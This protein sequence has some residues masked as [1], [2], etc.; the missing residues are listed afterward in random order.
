MVGQR[1]AAATAAGSAVEQLKTI[2]VLSTRIDWPGSGG[3]SLDPEALRILQ[4]RASAAVVS[5]LSRHEAIAERLPSGRVLGFFGVPVVH[6]DDPIRA[7]RAALEIR[8]TIAA[9]DEELCREARI[10]VAA[11]IGIDSGEVIVGEA[12]L[13]VGSAVAAAEALADRAAT[14]TILVGDGTARLTAASFQTDEAPSA[15]ELPGRQLL[16]MT[17][18][19]SLAQIRDRC[20][21][22]RD[23]ELEGLRQAFLVAV[24]ERLPQLVTV[25]GEA[26]IGKSR[27]AREFTASVSSEAIAL[28]G[29]CLPYGD[30]I[31]YWPLTEIVRHAD[32]AIAAGGIAQLLQDEPDASLISDRLARGIGMGQKQTTA[33]ETAW[34]ARRFFQVLAHRR[35]LVLLFEDL[36]WAE[37]GLLD[38]IEHVAD[39]AVD[40]PILLLCLARPQLLDDRASWG[41]G[42]RNAITL[43]LDSLSGAESDALLAGLSGQSGLTAQTRARVKAV[44]EG[45]PLFLEQSAAMFA[46]SGPADDLAVPP[47]IQALLVAR[48]ERLGPGER[49]VIECASIAGRDFWHGSVARAPPDGGSRACSE[50]PIDTRAKGAD[51]T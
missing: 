15:G 35:P 33:E 51:P 38:L 11:R 31:T 50:A 16:A 22:G 9:L 32:E 18:E 44:A 1:G 3:D 49:A 23:T 10:R 37:P 41:A 25:F 7:A 6:E 2:T 39:R 20:F 19:A 30:G 28:A 45:N 36:H 13:P 4:T 24:R 46:E 27:L 14:G 8:D 48:L 47:S 34:A 26:G 43:W 40:A 42:R 21:V 12:R 5:I 17:A 29:R